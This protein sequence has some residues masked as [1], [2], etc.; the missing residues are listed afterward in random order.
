MAAHPAA[1]GIASNQVHRSPSFNCGQQAGI[2]VQII[3]CFEASATA[4]AA[5]ISPRS[6]GW[7]HYA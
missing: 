4:S 1:V 7:G 3:D 2:A 5:V 6:M